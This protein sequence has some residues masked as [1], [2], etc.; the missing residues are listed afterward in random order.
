MS[1]IWKDSEPVAQYI[2]PEYEYTPQP[3]HRVRRAE[4]S[5]D[6]YVDVEYVG[7]VG[8]QGIYIPGKTRAFFGRRPHKRIRPWIK[9]E[10]G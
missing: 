6:Q 4:W 1:D 5:E 9:V 3:G 2:W 7:P 10:K 8:L